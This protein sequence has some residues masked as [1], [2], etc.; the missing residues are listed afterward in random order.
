MVDEPPVAVATPDATSNRRARQ[1]ARPA[2]RQPSSQ[3]SPP[4]VPIP[5]YETSATDRRK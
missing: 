4:V 1:P 3:P 2:A 5:D